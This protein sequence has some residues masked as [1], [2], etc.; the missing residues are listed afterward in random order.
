MN[1]NFRKGWLIKNS[2]T[3]EQQVYLRDVNLIY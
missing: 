1:L 2:Y 3:N